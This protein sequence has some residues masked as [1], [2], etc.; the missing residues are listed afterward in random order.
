MAE[1]FAPTDCLPRCISLT[2]LE[3][4][5]WLWEEPHAVTEP[6]AVLS[7][8][9]EL[10]AVDYTELRHPVEEEASHFSSLTAKAITSQKI[11]GSI[12]AKLRDA[13]REDSRN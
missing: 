11:G 12:E 10:D 2:R 5:V 1:E 4:A 3:L 7:S 8:M 9:P 13:I 6:V